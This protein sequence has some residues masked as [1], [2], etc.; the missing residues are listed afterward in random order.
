MEI[1]KLIEGAGIVGF[2]KA[3]RIECLGHIQRMYQ[4]RRT[5]KLLV[6]KPMGTRPVERPRQRWQDDVMEDIKK[7]ESK[8]LE[9][10]N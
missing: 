7:A 1:D 10:N 2:I 3:Q 9:G 8:I 5:R 6:W 4:A